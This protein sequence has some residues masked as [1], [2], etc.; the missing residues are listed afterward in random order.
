[1][2]ECPIPIRRQYISMHEIILEHVP[3]LY[4]CPHTFFTSQS[5]LPMSPYL[6][7]PVSHLYYFLKFVKNFLCACLHVQLLPKCVSLVQRLVCHNVYDI[8]CKYIYCTY[9]IYCMCIKATGSTTNSVVILHGR[10]QRCRP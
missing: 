6:F 9:Y 1:M 3:S 10:T 7:L 8:Y 4:P 5:S 2:T